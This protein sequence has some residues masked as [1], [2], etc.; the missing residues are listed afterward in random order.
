MFIIICLKIDQLIIYFP[1]VP[2]EQEVMNCSKIKTIDIS[3]LLTE[4]I[5]RMHNNESLS[6]LFTEVSV[7]D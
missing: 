2:H 6:Y 4:A 3:L 1:P 5:R 7:E